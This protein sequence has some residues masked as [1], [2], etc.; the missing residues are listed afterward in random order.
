MSL[1]RETMDLQINERWFQVTVDPILDDN[2]ECSKYIHSVSD[3]TDRIMLEQQLRQGQKMEAIGTLA[4][5]IAHDFNNILGIIMGNSELAL[6][7][8]GNPEK[9][10]QHL[11]LVGKA[12]ERARGLVQ[13][14]LAFS[15]RSIEQ[16]MPLQVSVIIKEALKML[17]ASIPTT[18]EIKEQILAEGLAEADPTQIHQVM[19]NL[20][21]NA[22][23]AMRETG[24]TLTVSLE[25][26]ELGS[27]RPGVTSPPA[28]RY[29]KLTVTDTGV[30]IAPQL[31]DKIFE[32]YFTTKP[33]GE[34]TGLGLAVVHGI[35]MSHHGHVDVSSEVGAGTSVH[36]YLPMMERQGIPRPVAVETLPVVIGHGE[37][38]LFVDDEELLCSLAESVFPEHGYQVTTFTMPLHAL[39]EF[40]ARPDQ[41][42]LVIT[43][44]TM[45]QIT[46]TE[47]SRRI[48][49][50]RRDIPVI[51]CTGYSSILSGKM[52]TS[53]AGITTYLT[54]PLYP[55]ATS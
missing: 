39:D 35:V 25:E 52:D 55:T 47:L 50:V 32:P 20:C 12:T 5:G 46:G 30:G 42:D 15:R 49:A 8:V 27:K 13:Q 22:Y 44:M 36:V 38:I 29:L 51:L 37:R 19:M 3:I 43:D 23:Q 24:G 4:G 34:G 54:K 1:R 14:I 9:V 2:G 31:M 41:F 26:I 28:G 17:R 18:I 53:P 16:R 7:K 11:T 48:H 45:P 6:L 21:T 40:S 33:K 10:H